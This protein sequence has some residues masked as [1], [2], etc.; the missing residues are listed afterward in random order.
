MEKKHP[1]TCYEMF[2]IRH[3]TC[4]S[5]KHKWYTVLVWYIQSI[6]PNTY[7]HKQLH[8]DTV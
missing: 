2:L 5:A 1:V 8:I 7:K 3:H 4:Y 6:L